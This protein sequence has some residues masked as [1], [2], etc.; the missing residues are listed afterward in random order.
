MKK[1][2]VPLV[3][4]QIKDLETQSVVVDIIVTTLS[5]RR[6]VAQNSSDFVYIF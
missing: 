4:E 1:I 3:I 2:F 6:L 5:S